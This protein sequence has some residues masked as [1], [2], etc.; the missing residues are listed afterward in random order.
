MAEW[1]QNLTAWATIVSA[2]ATA[3]LFIV[4]VLTAWVAIGT[5]RETVRA[6]NNAKDAS[7]QASEQAAQD[8]IRRTRPYV[9]AEIKPSI[10]GKANYDLI[11]QNVGHSTAR[12]LVVSFDPTPDDPDDIASKV[13]TDLKQKRDLPPTARIRTIWQL[14]LAE[15]QHFVDAEGNRSTEP[16]GL[17]NAGTIT[18]SY[19]SD[20][21]S[22]PHYQEQY[23]FDV[24]VAGLWPVPEDGI[25]PKNLDDTAKAI[26][27]ALAT[28]ARHLGMLRW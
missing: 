6:N 2:A 20:D 4:A 13:L 10:T 26:H 9:F 5:L 16:A 14:G 18:L 22:H 19:T 25:D 27:S 3:G 15:N 11:I 24:D 28:S 7:I 23:T 1:L 12:D 17:D 21:E 8:S